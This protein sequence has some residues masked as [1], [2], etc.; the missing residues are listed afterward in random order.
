MNIICEDREI[1][2]LK[3]WLDDK[4]IESSVQN[5]YKKKKSLITKVKILLKKDGIQCCYKE[6]I[7]RKVWKKCRPFIK[8][9]FFCITRIINLGIEKIPHI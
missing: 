3:Q 7:K 5:F 2:A 9:Q 4:N 6:I 1:S 8:I